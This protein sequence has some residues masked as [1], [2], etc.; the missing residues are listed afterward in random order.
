MVTG[1]LSFYYDSAIY[2]NIFA[3]NRS[4]NIRYNNDNDYM[5]LINIFLILYYLLH[6][7]TN[8]SNIVTVIA[9]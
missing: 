7:L 5:Y 4:D 1:D 9:I 6:I 2:F 3:M 8:N